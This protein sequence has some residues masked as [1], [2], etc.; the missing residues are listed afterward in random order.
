MERAGTFSPC[1]K[2][3]ASM[4]DTV[5]L[6]VWRSKIVTGTSGSPM[7]PT[8]L[9][10]NF[11]CLLEVY[12]LFTMCW[13]LLTFS[14]KINTMYSSCKGFHEWQGLLQLLHYA[15]SSWWEKTWLQRL[16]SWSQIESIF[17]LDLQTPGHGYHVCPLL[18]IDLCFDTTFQEMAGRFIWALFYLTN[19]ISSISSS[20]FCLCF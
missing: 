3:A 16:S 14:H 2:I 18:E 13:S 17:G 12:I 19:S 15:S 8:C 1:Y 9:Q 4:I 11:M 7:R 20:T 6:A 10:K 5:W